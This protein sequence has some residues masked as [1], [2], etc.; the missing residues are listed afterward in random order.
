MRP[1]FFSSELR[2][3][4]MLMHSEALRN[5]R[6]RKIKSRKFHRAQRKDK[7]KQAIREF[8]QLKVTNPQAALEKL[9]DLERI[10]REERVSLRHKTKNRW[11]MQ[12]AKKGKF[13]KEAQ[14]SLRLVR[15]ESATRIAWDNS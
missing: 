1:I 7:M 11:A 12:V 14:E 10:R 15:A 4:R 13:D 5:R 6:V 9:E 8:E 3:L 2:K